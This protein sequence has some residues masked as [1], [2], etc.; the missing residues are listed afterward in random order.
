MHNVLVLLDGMED[1]SGRGLRALRQVLRLSVGRLSSWHSVSDDGDGGCQQSAPGHRACQRIAGS[2]AVRRAMGAVQRPPRHDGH[3]AARDGRP[4]SV[5]VQPRRPSDDVRGRLRP[6]E[7][8]PCPS[9][10]SHRN[11]WSSRTASNVARLAHRMPSRGR[12]RPA[13]SVGI[14][15]PGMSTRCRRAAGLCSKPATLTRASSTASTGSVASVRAM[16]H[17]NWSPADAM[18]YDTSGRHNRRT[19]V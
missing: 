11:R 9:A 18:G 1:V 12:W 8:P 17:L 10:E 13:I 15:A 7:A 14:C 4:A 6:G 5:P 3:D 16:V 19:G 2:D